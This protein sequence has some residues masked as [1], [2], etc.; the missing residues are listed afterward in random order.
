MKIGKIE[1][2]TLRAE[3]AEDNVRYLKTSEGIYKTK[4]TQL[5]HELAVCGEECGGMQEEIERLKAEIQRLDDVSAGLALYEQANKA[6][7]EQCERLKKLLKGRCTE[8]EWREN[9]W[10]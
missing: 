1:Q 10:T 4:I 7:R 5:E 8:E 3:H 9:N 2:L 6:L